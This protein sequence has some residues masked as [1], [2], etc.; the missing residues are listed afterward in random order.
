MA[1]SILQMRKTRHR[2]E[3]QESGEQGASVAIPGQAGNMR[4]EDGPYRLSR[5]T[6]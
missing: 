5:E 6:Y 3:T 4:R 1:I 2:K